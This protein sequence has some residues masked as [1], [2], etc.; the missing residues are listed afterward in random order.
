MSSLTDR[1]ARRSLR[2]ERDGD[3]GYPRRFNLYENCY[4]SAI[5]NELSG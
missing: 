3:G 4:K 2:G 5:P 1:H